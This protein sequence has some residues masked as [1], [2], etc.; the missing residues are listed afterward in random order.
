MLESARVDLPARPSPSCGSAANLVGLAQATD[1]E[2]V[3][4]GGAEVLE[5][6]RVVRM[7]HSVSFDIR[8]RCWWWP[9]L[10][11]PR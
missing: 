3:A 9:L 7:M 8:R 4:T 2:L 11:R 5:L 10:M 6:V 1:K